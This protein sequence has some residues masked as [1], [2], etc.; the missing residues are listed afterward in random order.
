ML[1]LKNSSLLI[2]ILIAL[3]PMFFA[4]SD[5]R[6]EESD[7]PKTPLKEIESSFSEEDKFIKMQQE[8]DSSEELNFGPTLD[9]LNTST[10]TH[11]SA[12]VFFDNGKTIKKIV[13]QEFGN[14]GSTETCSYYFSDNGSL[15]SWKS[16]MTMVKG[17]TV[18]FTIIKSY[19][20][21]SENTLF[22]F[23]KSS[24]DYDSLEFISF[25]RIDIIKKDKKKLLELVNQQGPFETLF[26]GFSEFN[27]VNF[28][29]V[30]TDDYTSTLE[31]TTNSKGDI[32]K[33]LNNN[34]T[35]LGKKLNI[36]FTK[37][38]K[39]DNIEYQKLLNVKILN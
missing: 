13:Y 37:Y 20:D 18:L 29:V 35:Y 27:G 24:V 12:T 1:K 22:T 5:D 17:E 33:L 2:V 23:S 15:F 28:M 8:I 36:L 32:K 9:Y 11:T 38:T 16:E 10:E 34:T 21:S 6:V 14:D 31:I 26:R 30:G 39:Q 4:C 7:P 19:L 3:F 25:N